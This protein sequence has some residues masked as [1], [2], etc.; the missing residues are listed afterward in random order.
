MNIHRFVP[1]LAT[2]VAFASGCVVPVAMFPSEHRVGGGFIGGE[3]RGNAS[4][5]P[6]TAGGAQLAYRAS[7]TPLAVVPELWDRDFDFGLGYFVMVSEAG[8]FQHGAT[9]DFSYFLLR[10]NLDDRLP[11]DPLAPPP[12]EEA[13]SCTPAGERQLLRI[14]L[15]SE[16]DIRFSDPESNI[17]VGGRG[18]LRFDFSFVAGQ[19]TSAAGQASARSIFLGT[20]WGEYGVAFDVLGGGGVVGAQTYGEVLV[21]LTLRAPAIAG[22]IIGVP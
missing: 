11:C 4:E 14:A 2:L 3:M 7:I 19:P 18:G 22:V 16:L 9:G 21:A 10:A 15:R 8:S 1:I 17:G 5:P 20:S 13:P 6:H 12:G